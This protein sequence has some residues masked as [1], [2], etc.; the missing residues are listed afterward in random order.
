M[1]KKNIFQRVEWAKVAIEILSVVFAVLLALF[2]NEWRNNIKQNEQLNQARANL[3]EEL[4][5]NLEETKSKLALHQS[6]LKY[7]EHLMDSVK[8]FELPFNEYQVSVGL[9]NLKDAVW[10][11]ITLTDVV[12]QLKFEEISDYSELYRGYEF[13]DK[14]QNTY[15]EQVF[16]MEFNK[17]ENSNQGYLVTKNHLLQMITWEEE[18]INEI[19]GRL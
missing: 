3:R 6:Q 18:L 19:E 15:L 1:S 11:S 8:S 10:Q 9:L 16:S 5:Y 12:N 2:L 13:I 17:V 4:V 14:L 7:L